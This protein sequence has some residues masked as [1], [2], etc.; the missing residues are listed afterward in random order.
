MT[1]VTESYMHSTAEEL[2]G[3][4]M[5]LQ[6]TYKNRV[7]PKDFVRGDQKEYPIKPLHL[8]EKSK[9]DFGANYHYILI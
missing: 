3:F 8:F 7:Y 5:R 4:Q 2:T 9:F 6:Y 1:L